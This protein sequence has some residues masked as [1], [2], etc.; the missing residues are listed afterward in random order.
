[1]Q[2][3]LDSLFKHTPP[4]AL[5][6]DEP[7]LFVAARDHLARKGVIAPRDISL[8]CCDYD[9]LFDWCIPAVTHIAWQPR[10]VLARVVKWA[11]NVGRGKEDKRTNPTKARL[12]S[13]STIGPVPA[14]AGA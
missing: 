5:L 13:G 4:T 7:S 6:L 3:L 14:S 8:A 12:V 9:P 10:P 11:G 1:M 2:K